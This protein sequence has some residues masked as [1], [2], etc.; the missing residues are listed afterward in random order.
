MQGVEVTVDVQYIDIQVTVSLEKQFL[1]GT[2]Q[3]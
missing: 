2:I 1:T 3:N